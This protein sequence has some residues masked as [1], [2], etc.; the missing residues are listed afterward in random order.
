LPVIDQVAA[1]YLDEVRFIAVAGR[2][3]F[4]ATAERA[5]Q[6]FSRLDWGYD[7]TIWDLYGIPGQ[8][9]SVLITGNDVIVDRWFGAAGEEQLRQSLDR[10]VAL[11][12]N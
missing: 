5:P 3:S 2:S 6:W 12:G 9:A 11:G 4:E 7:E 8:P 1:D 10:L